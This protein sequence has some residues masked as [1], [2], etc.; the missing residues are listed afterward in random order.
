MFGTMRRE[1]DAAGVR[2]I[3]RDRSVAEAAQLLAQPGT[4]ALVV[5]E[6]EADGTVTGLLTQRD[7]FRAVAADGPEIYSRSVWL[8][9]DPDFPAVDIGASAQE[10]LKTFCE[11]RVDHIALMESCRIRAILS[12]WDCAGQEF[13]KDIGANIGQARAAATPQASPHP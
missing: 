7:I 8:I 5:V 10:R 9:T 3:H 1:P 13:G 2:T 4:G 6:G 12:I 11:R